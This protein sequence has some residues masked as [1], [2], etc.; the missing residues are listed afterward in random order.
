V[1]SVFKTWV[2]FVVFITVIHSSIEESAL[3]IQYSIQKIQDWEMVIAPLRSMKTDLYNQSKNLLNV[4]EHPQ[5]WSL[6]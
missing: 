5:K 1:F 2:L 3:I 4:D 6:L